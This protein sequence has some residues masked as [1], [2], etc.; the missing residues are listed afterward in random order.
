MFTFS[1]R[2]ILDGHSRSCHLH[3][4]SVV[5]GRCILGG[6]ASH[7]VAQDFG[8]SCHSVALVDFLATKV[9][10][11]G[12]EPAEISHLSISQPIT[13]ELG[14]NPC[15]ALALHFGRSNCPLLAPIDPGLLTVIESWTTLPEH[16]KKTVEHLVFLANPGEQNAT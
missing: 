7:K 3:T 11:T 6:A 16:I 13:C 9:E 10:G 2:N 8:V 4:R 5:H 1:N 15:A 14:G 12:L